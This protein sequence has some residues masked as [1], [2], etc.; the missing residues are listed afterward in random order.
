MNT[1]EIKIKQYFN[2]ENQVRIC[3]R[4]S[5][6]LW[7]SASINHAK[8]I[9]V[10]LNKTTAKL[11]KTKMDVKMMA[12]ATATSTLMTMLMTTKTTSQKLHLQQMAYMPRIKIDIHLTKI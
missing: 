8:S 10:L 4:K 9:L 3:F 6:Q 5:I 2:W 1:N 11:I 7:N 12:A